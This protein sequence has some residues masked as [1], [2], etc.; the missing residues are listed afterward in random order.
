MTRPAVLLAALLSVPSL[1]A[2]LTPAE[3]AKI[4]REQQEAQDA[5]AKKY[6]N[7]KLSELSNAERSAMA[8]EQ[9]DAQQKVLDQNR[10]SQKD[11]AV[12]SMR[13]GRTEKAETEAAARALEAEAKKKKSAPTPGKGSGE[14]QIQRGFGNDKPAVMEDKGGGEPEIEIQRGPTG[15]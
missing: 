9:A 4:Q 11:W 2:G 15:K 13:M 8:R 12:S 14:I 3:R 6:G 1:A 5:V 10:V 7:R